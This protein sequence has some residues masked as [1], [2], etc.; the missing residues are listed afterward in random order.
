MLWKT[1]SQ[2]FTVHLNSVDDDI[3][4]T[5]EGEVMTDTE[6]RE[7]VDGEEVSVKVERELAFLDMWTMVETDGSISIKVIRKETHTNQ[8][9]NFGSNHPLEGGGGVIRH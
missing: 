2:E 4:W 1:Q 9:L 8:Y 7:M 5:T 6:V 3:N